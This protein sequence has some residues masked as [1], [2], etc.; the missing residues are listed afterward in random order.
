MQVQDDEEMKQRK[1]S[2][3]AKLFPSRVD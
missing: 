2:I 3:E 1:F